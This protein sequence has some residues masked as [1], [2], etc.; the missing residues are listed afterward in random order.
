MFSCFLFWMFHLLTTVTFKETFLNTPNCGYPMDGLLFSA[1]ICDGWLCCVDSKAHLR[2]QSPSASGFME[3]KYY[4]CQRWCMSPPIISLEYKLDVI[5]CHIDPIHIQYF[6][7]FSTTTSGCSRDPTKSH[8][9]MD[10]N[11]ILPRRT[12][13][14]LRAFSRFDDPRRIWGAQ[15]RWARS[16]LLVGSVFF[17]MRGLLANSRKGFLFLKKTW[18]D[19]SYQT[20]LQTVGF[21][22][23]WRFQ[24]FFYRWTGCIPTAPFRRF[25]SEGIC[26]N[27]RKSSSHMPGFNHLL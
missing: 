26:W 18:K 1:A 4:T 2:I 6:K 3:H 7:G 21:R 5:I 15:K 16:E 9:T 12:P 22:K 10:P 11:G 23:H 25:G 17:S 14:G 20:E 24:D 19:L 8:M 27:C 13:R